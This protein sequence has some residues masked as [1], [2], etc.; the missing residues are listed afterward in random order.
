MTAQTQY[1][2]DEKGKRV[3]VVLDISTYQRLMSTTATDPE[4]LS[5]LNQE[6]LRA[7]AAS[8][9]AHTS[10]TQLHSLLARQKEGALTAG[11]IA[12][13]DDLLVQVDQLTVLK[14]RARHTLHTTNQ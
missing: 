4:L 1:L 6:E 14:T 5:G 13:I 9:L 12:E 2:T 8:Q 3:G 11:E 7:L 10:Q